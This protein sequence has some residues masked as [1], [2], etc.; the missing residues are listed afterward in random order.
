MYHGLGGADGV[1][2]D[3]FEAQLDALQQR[4][5]VVSLADAVAALG[6]SEASALAAIT[7]DDGYRDFS[8]LAV[9]RL[10]ARG[11]HATLFVPA[12]HVGAVN[13]WDTGRA[14]ERRLLD[15]GELRALDAASV[16]IGAH[17]LNHCRL[18]ALA[19]D[20]LRTETAEARRRLEDLCARP[21]RF[22]AYPY[23]QLDDFDLA[24]EVAVA[25]AGFEAACSTHFGRGSRADERFRLRRVGITPNDDLASA[26]RKWD[27]AY[28]WVSWKERVGASL[29]RR[30]RSGISGSPST[31]R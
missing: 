27:G 17:G 15:A 7:F 23:G 20:R 16:E 18:A 13:V 26:C 28:D 30:R 10:A 21:V 31:Y 5:R 11:L 1:V 2:P 4:R 3:Q 9:P 25:A 29:R 22:F 14:V 19:P 6:T 24:A 12:G 8:E